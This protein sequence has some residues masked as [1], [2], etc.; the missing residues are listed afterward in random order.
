[1]KELTNSFLQVVNRLEDAGLDLKA[2]KV[3]LVISKHEGGGVLELAKKG[4]ISKS[5][6][7]RYVAVLAGGVPKAIP[8]NQALISMT[9][10]DHRTKALRLTEKGSKLIKELGEYV[11]LES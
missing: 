5:V 11:S 3:L 4:N 9:A 2:F 1:M 8:S 6:F 10:I 7:S